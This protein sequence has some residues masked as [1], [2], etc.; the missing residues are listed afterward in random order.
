MSDEQT[1]DD[2]LTPWQA[3]SLTRRSAALV[4]RGLAEAL[5]LRS[6]AAYFNRGLAKKS[7]GD[8]DGAIDDYTRAIE[9]NPR[10]AA[11]YN[12]RGLARYDNGDYDLAFD[13]YTKAIEINT[14]DV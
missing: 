4:R 3:Q 12:N 1:K 2:A 10:D 8:D 5:T 13:D 7:I 6:S 14:R 11:A 9:I